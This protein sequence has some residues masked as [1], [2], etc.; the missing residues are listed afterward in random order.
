[1]FGHKNSYVDF[2]QIGGCTH[3]LSVYRLGNADMRPL[4]FTPSAF[5]ILPAPYRRL[6]SRAALIK[7]SA[8]CL[9]PKSY[10]FRSIHY[11]VSPYERGAVGQN[12]CA[13][14]KAFPLLYWSTAGISQSCPVSGPFTLYRDMCLLDTS[15]ITPF[16][17]EQGLSSFGPSGC[18]RAGGR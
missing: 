17:G 10:S 4:R 7:C 15:E 2:R 9:F 18:M 16:R 1:M 13:T 12:R 3:S 5:I 6:Q 11:N 14:L 8:T